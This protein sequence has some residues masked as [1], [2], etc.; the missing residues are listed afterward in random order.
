MDPMPL[1]K[2]F[3]RRILAPT[4]TA[5]GAAASPS[6][7]PAG[8]VDVEAAE[9][10]AENVIIEDA[11]PIE[12]PYEVSAESPEKLVH[13]AFALLGRIVGAEKAKE[14]W[15]AALAPKRPRGRPSRAF[16]D[17][18]A[19]LIPGIMKFARAMPGARKTKYVEAF[20]DDMTSRGYKIVGKREATIARL[21]RYATMMEKKGWRFR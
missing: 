12:P 7:E 8:R 4:K 19:F 3:H 15:A 17:D 16:R 9:R 11:T 14:L 21:V 5:A 10:L 6:A 13:D 2:T 18:D 20:V 1:R